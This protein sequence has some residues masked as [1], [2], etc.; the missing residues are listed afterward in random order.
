MLEEIAESSGKVNDLVA[1]ISAAAAEQSQGIEQVNTAV[2]Q[3]DKVT[4]QNASSSEESASAAEELNS[5]AEELQK[6]VSEFKLTNGSAVKSRAAKTKKVE[7]R[8]DFE[9]PA[10]AG[11]GRKNRVHALTAHQG[12]TAKAEFK[13]TIKD[14]DGN[15]EK[16][17]PPQDVI[18]LDDADFKDF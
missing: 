5:Q 4:Q 11:E 13:G 16:K 6:M 12:T 1:E 3:M 8:L 10:K 17:S 7:H 18:P 2:A 9:A 15:G 14:G